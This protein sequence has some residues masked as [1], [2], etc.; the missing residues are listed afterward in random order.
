M[1]ESHK[2][3]DKKS[4]YK[5]KFQ[6]SKRN[7]EIKKGITG[8][9]V[10]CDSKDEKRCVKE[11]FNVLNDYVEKVYPD[12]DTT[13][14]LADPNRQKATDELQQ[15]IDDLKHGKRLWYTFDM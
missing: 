4:F 12:L 10:T 3:R 2:K 8:F 15:E 1:V 13:A 7:E 9:L 14:L 5:Q 11:I 6:D